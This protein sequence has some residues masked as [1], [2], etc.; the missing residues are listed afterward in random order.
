MAVKKPAV[1]EDPQH[2]VL[3]KN[4]KKA[5]E[6]Y[7]ASIQDDPE[8]TNT[9]LR[10]GDCLVL[11]GDVGGAVESYKKAAKL[12]ADLGFLLKAIGINKKIV[13]LDP[14]QEDVHK[15]LSEQAQERGLLASPAQRSRGAGGM[16]TFDMEE[17]AGDANELAAGGGS[18]ELRLEPVADLSVDDGLVDLIDSGYASE[19]SVDELGDALSDLPSGDELGAD[20]AG[21]ALVAA[22][23]DGSVERTPLF[24]DFTAAELV[25]VVKKMSGEGAAKGQTVVRE[26]DP[27]D[28]LYVIVSGSLRVVTR[29]GG[30][31]LELAVLGEGEFFGEGA[32]IT[33]KAR[34][35]TIIANED[36]ELLSLSRSALD[37]IVRTHPRVKDVMLQFYQRRAES[38]VRSILQ[39]KR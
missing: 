16:M 2:Y 20:L 38:T 11:A 25:E 33:G 8:D 34:T 13:K 15:R 35:A 4:Y 10:L 36:S 31:E 30:K 28:A 17:S 18:A 26:G 39:A 1:R 37:E 24:S 12:Y 19:L 29:A 5:V 27:G 6:L 9:Y 7:R 32:L 22:A 21:A 14:S 3:K 23:R